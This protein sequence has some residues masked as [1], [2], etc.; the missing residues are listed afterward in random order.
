[1]TS[2]QTC[3]NIAT[4]GTQCINQLPNCCFA[5]SVFPP[6]EGMV[7]TS[8]ILNIISLDFVGVFR[9]VSRRILAQAVEKLTPFSGDTGTFRD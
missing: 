3:N 5:S 9:D 8:G 1:M 7:T 6:I 4:D 2:I